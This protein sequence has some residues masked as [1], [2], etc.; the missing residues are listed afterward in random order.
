MQFLARRTVF[1]IPGLQKCDNICQNVRSVHAQGHEYL[2][3]GQTMNSFSTKMCK[4]LQNISKH[5]ETFCNSADLDISVDDASP[6]AG[7][8]CLHHLTKTKMKKN[9]K[10][11]KDV[12]EMKGEKYPK[13]PKYP[14]IST[15]LSE[16]IPGELLLK[17]ALLGDE[18]EKVFARLGTLH[19][20]DEAV[21]AL[22]VVKEADHTF[23]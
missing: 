7:Y 6:S 1:E 23:S 20:D 2:G 18:V 14:Q 15:N 10:D 19:H 16:E 21:V 22:K 8:Y 11:K 12:I 5:N 17:N 9:E 3:N 13:Y 4:P